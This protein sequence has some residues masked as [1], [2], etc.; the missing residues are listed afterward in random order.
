MIDDGPGKTAVSVRERFPD[1][2]DPRAAA[3]AEADEVARLL[4]NRGREP[5]ARYPADGSRPAGEPLV[6]RDAYG[7]R[8]LLVA[9]FSYDGGAPDHWYAWD[10]DVCW[11]VVVVGAGVSASAEDALREW[12]DA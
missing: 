8:L 3:L 9:P 10:I 4:A 2:N 5:G 11:I 1:I 12:R 7:S 6:A